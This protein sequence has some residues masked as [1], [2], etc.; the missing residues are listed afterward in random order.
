MD[1][2]DG[3]TVVGGWTDVAPGDERTV[4]VRYTLPRK[5]DS[6][7]TASC[8]CCC[9]KPGGTAVHASAGIRHL[10]GLPL[11]AR[12]GSRGRPDAPLARNRPHRPQPAPS[13]RG[14]GLD[15]I[16]F[17]FDLVRPALPAAL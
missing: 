4:T 17:H 8:R 1:E 15:G 12:W 2:Q 16:R 5:L 7:A 9:A 10:A 14:L 3:F 6:T 13:L 11:A